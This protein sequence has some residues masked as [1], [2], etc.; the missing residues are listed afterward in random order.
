MTHPDHIQF[1]TPETLPST[2]GFSQIVKVTGG[3]TIYLAGQ[4]AL[5]ASGTLVGRGDF[6][7]QAQYIF[8]NIQ[9]ALAAVG[10]DF[11][12]VV[13]LNMY[14]VDRSQLPL[15]REVRD[16]YVNKQTPPVSTLVE[17][18]S[19]AQE[20]FLLEIEAIASLPA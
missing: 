16:L 2:P 3:Q 8:E 14:V 12:H 6:R 5:D 1:L 11:S 10:A 15:L 19:L 13:K 18:R 17:V 20:Q 9:T 7:T 4:V